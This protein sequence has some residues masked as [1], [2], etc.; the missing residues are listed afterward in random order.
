MP[1]VALTQVQHLVVDLIKLPRV[2]MGPILEYVQVP[3]DGILSFRCV[4]C[5]SQ[6]GVICKFAQS[7]LDSF[8]CAIN[9]DIK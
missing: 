5:M 3:V 2:A 8:V 1:G 9:E 6:L 7:A 4:N